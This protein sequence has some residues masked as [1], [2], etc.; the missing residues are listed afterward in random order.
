MIFFFNFKNRCSWWNFRNIKIHFRREHDT[1]KN[2]AD[3]PDRSQSIGKWKDSIEV[4]SK[5][6]KSRISKN[7]L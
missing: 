1:S 4:D 3:W 6:F 7:D 5:K 2:R